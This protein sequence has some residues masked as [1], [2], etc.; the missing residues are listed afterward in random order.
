[1]LEVKGYG[2]SDFTIS[3]S[4]SSLFIYKRSHELHVARDLGHTSF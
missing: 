3:E 1:M 4:F 2:F